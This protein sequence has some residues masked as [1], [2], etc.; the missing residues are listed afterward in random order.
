MRGSGGAFNC[1]SDM[2]VRDGLQILHRDYD[3]IFAVWIGRAVQFTGGGD[4]C[5]SNAVNIYRN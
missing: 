2:T 3:C 5:G 4:D 1:H